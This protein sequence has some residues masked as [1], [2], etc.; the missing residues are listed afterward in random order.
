MRISE[1]WI[2]LVVLSFNKL[3]KHHSAKR[4]DCTLINAISWINFKNMMLGKSSNEVDETG[5]SSTE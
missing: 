5:A 1:G 4:N 3:S 2:P